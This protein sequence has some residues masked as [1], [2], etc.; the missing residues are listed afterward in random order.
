ME[1]HEVRAEPEDSPETSGERFDTNGWVDRCCDQ[2]RPGP[3]PQIKVVAEL[4]SLVT[5]G[6]FIKAVHLWLRCLESHLR[7][8]EGVVCCW[9]LELNIPMFVWSTD[10]SVLTMSS[11]K[12]MIRSGRTW[13]RLQ[14][15]TSQLQTMCNSYPEASNAVFS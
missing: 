8:A 3:G 2:D 7:H 5:I 14:P 12:Q 11:G 6:Q 15:K 1:V 9:L 13:L 4:G 10:I